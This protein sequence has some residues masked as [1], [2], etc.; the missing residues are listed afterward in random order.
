[1]AESQSY[2]TGRHKDGRSI[3]PVIQ[4]E[5]GPDGNLGIR[6]DCC[7]ELQFW[8]QLYI[9]PTEIQEAL[10]GSQGTLQSDDSV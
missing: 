6:V 7:D 4:L 10:N 5:A 8:L 1:M 3:R 2:G 9:D